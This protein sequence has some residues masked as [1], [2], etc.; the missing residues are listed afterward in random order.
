MKL[1]F[2]ESTSKGCSDLETNIR[3]CAQAGFD[4]IELRFDM[5]YPYLEQHSI[6]DIKRLFKENNIKPHALNAIY[7][8]ADLFGDND[9][10][11]RCHQFLKEFISACTLAK[12]LES[13][14]IVVV[15]PMLPGVYT[16]Q[17]DRDE[18]TC[19]ADYLRI[20]SRLAD[21]AAD[22]DVKIGLEPV[23]APKC[24]IKTVSVT[25]SIIR[26]INKPNVGITLDSYNLYM[27][28][29]DSCCYKEIDLLDAD[30]IFVIHINNAD[31]TGPS[32]EARCMCDKGVIDLDYFLGQLKKKGYDGMVSLEVFR[33]EYWEMKP[34]EL[35]PLSYKTT[36]EVLERNNCL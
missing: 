11:V 28:Y 20:A 32:L 2:N 1:C 19:R 21:I 22:Y 30:R 23:G 36:K 3:L 31:A 25:D 27:A 33:P 10:K 16:A 14:Y 8:Y 6:S 18:E 9:D 34:E 29:M 26:E 4:Y 5:I 7:T 12:E 15:P 13:N 35:I 24:S 17:Y